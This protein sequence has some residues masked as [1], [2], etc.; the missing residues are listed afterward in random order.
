[1]GDFV[2][3]RK[4]GEPLWPERYTLQS[5][6]RIKNRPGMSFWWSA[7]CQQNPIPRGGGKVEREWFSRIVEEVPINC[8]RVRYWDKARQ[9]RRTEA[10]LTWPVCSWRSTRTTR[11]MWKMWSVG[12]WNFAERNRV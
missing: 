9:R 11:C 1:G 12:Q 7:L 6:L 2:F 5:L 4:A 3:S 10:G 8:R